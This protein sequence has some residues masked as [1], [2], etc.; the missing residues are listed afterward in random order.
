MNWGDRLNLI[1]SGIILLLWVMPAEGKLEVCRG[2]KDARRVE[3][4]LFAVAV[5]L[6]IPLPYSSPL[7]GEGWGGGVYSRKG[8]I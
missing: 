2:S 5:F 7:I 4:R 1:C 8:V 3:N 6:F